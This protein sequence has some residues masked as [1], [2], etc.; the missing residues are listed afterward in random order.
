M[1]LLKLASQ[2]NPKYISIWFRNDFP[3]GLS[4]VLLFLT[5]K[6]KSKGQSLPRE[7]L[8]FTR[9]ANNQSC[10][11]LTGKRKHLID[12]SDADILVQPR[13][14]EV[15]KAKDMLVFGFCELKR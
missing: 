6:Q 14:F 3:D 12:F 8:V 1:H 15:E 10:F 7:N 5:E 2:Q 9:P 13:L 4:L 11:Y